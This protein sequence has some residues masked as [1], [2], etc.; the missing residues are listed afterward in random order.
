M[1]RE[2]LEQELQELTTKYT[3]LINRITRTKEDLLAMNNEALMIKGAKE[4]V[5]KLL[6]FY[7]N[8]NNMEE[9][10]KDGKRSN[11]KSK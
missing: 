5:E 3:I 1:E 8:D 7:N 11:T 6:A 9:E 2:K 4:Q 10:K